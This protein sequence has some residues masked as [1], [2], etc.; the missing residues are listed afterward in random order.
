MKFDF[1]K[2]SKEQ[3]EKIKALLVEFNVIPAPVTPVVTPTT[4]PEVKKFGEAKLKDGTVIKWEGDSALAV[5]AS[6]LVIDPANPEGFLPIPNSPEEGYM[7]EDGTIFKV[8]DGKVTELTPAVAPVVEPVEQ[9]APAVV[10]QV[11]QMQ[12]QLDEVNS[13]FSSV[14]KEKETLNTELETLKAEFA[15]V[16]TTLSETVE[17]FKTA[18]ETPATEPAETPTYKPLSGIGSKINN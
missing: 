7:L 9:S 3:G 4:T 11:A 2:L 17:M 10:A 5:G 1:S 14:T 16:K 6:L 18:M 12:S 8:E 15:K 13:K